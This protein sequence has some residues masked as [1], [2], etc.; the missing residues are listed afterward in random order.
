MNDEKTLEMFL[1]LM[2]ELHANT[3]ALKEMLANHETRITV[4]EKD[5]KGNDWKSQLLM[6]L[7]K[8]IVIGSVCVG[9]LVGAGGIISKLGLG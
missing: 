6:L 3:T 7:A 8:A 9:S 1:K 4:L 5:N 2:E